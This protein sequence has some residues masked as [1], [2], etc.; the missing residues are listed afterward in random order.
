MSSERG[1]ADGCADEK[2]TRLQITGGRTD[3]AGCIGTHMCAYPVR[4][5]GWQHSKARSG[6]CSSTCFL[7]EQ[8]SAACRDGDGKPHF[9]PF[10]SFQPAHLPPPPATLRPPSRLFNGLVVIF[11][12]P[13]VENFQVSLASSLHLK[14]LVNISNRAGIDEKHLQYRSVL[15]PNPWA[16]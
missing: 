1:A 10:T 14:Q 3:Q 7:R 13:Q 2:G 5:N 11:S 6:E 12:V 9:R 16:A 15:W 4:Q 8:K